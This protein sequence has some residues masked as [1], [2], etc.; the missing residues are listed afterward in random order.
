MSF[1]LIFLIDYVSNEK[2]NKMEFLG[3]RTIVN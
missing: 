3:C 1:L 2:D